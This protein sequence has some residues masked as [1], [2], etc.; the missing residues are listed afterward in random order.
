VA[1]GSPGE[2]AEVIHRY[3]DAG[4]DTVVLSPTAAEA[5]LEG[6][7]ELAAAVREQL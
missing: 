4:V 1:V 6:V 5:D 2:V 3:A 7:L